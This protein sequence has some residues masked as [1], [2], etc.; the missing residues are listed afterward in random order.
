MKSQSGCTGCGCCLKAG[1][2]EG[3][4]T[5]LT[6][7]SIKACPNRLLRFSAEAYTPEALVKKL[8]GNFDI[9]K[10]SGGGITFSGG[11]PLA[12]FEGLYECL[13]LL[14]GKIHLAIQTTGYCTEDIFAKVLPLTDFFLYDIKLV[15]S[16]L[17]KRYTGVDNNL[18]L[19]NYA[20]LAKS[21]K[22][23]ITR[24]P[25][26]PGVTDT[27]ANLTA[28]AELLKANGID[29]IELLPYNKAAGGKYSTIGR[30][31]KPD[32]DESVPCNPHLEIFEKLNISAKLL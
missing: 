13:K 8:E 22:P 16:E 12:S 2:T 26:I 6:E 18:I 32:Y 5:V 14:Q 29:K 31:F 9:L 7:N 17:H 25:L 11:E 28:V 21:G 24:T 3:N 20:T 27:E 19:K 23:F 1:K 15:D 10:L 4:F 30:T